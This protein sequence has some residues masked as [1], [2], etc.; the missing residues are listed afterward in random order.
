MLMDGKVVLVTGS[1]RGIGR[2]IA[3]EAAR[4]GAKVVV[5]DLGGSVSG[6]DEGTTPAD[7]VVKEIVAAGGEAIANGDSVSDWDGAHRMVQAGVDAF[8]RIDSI[9]NVAGI[10]RDGMFHKMSEENF[11]AV[12]NV[13]LKGTFNVARAAVDHFKEQ[14]SGSMVHFSSTSGLVGAIG[15]ANYSAAKMGIVGLSR[16]IALEGARYGVR[17]NIVSP[18]AW[19]R[20]IESIPI[21]SD[22]QAKAMQEMKDTQQPEHISP[23]VV[24]LL[25]DAASKVSGQVFAVRGTEVM[26][27]S[28]PR[29]IA[30]MAN[31]GGWTPQQLADRAIPAFSKNLI[32]PDTSGSYFSWPTL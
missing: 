7:D 5:N 17:S 12:I 11:D 23:M 26:L 29:P 1:G 9:V 22:E 30:I 27:L 19:T 4:E 15:Q 20:M 14:G 13:H 18:F 2:A 24:C 32:E 6:E 8:G 28:Q 10:L 25:S 16:S 31:A 21:S 3:L